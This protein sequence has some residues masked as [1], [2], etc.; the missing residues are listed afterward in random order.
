MRNDLTSRDTFFI[1]L[2]LWTGVILVVAMVGIGGATRLTGS[3]LSIVEWKVISGTIPPLNQMEWEATF[4]KYK[5]FPEYQKLNQGMTLEG[6]KGIFWWEYFHRLIGRFT[7]IAFIVPFLIFVFAKKLSRPLFYQLLGVFV[8]GALQGVMGWVM[9]KSG[10]VDL[11][12]VSH[13]RL[14]A[15]LSLALLLVG[16]L[17]WIIQG[18]SPSFRSDNSH[19]SVVSFTYLFLAVVFIQLIYGAFVAGLK[20]GFSFNTFPLMGSE[21]FP[22]GIYQSAID[23]LENGVMVQFIHR[24]FALVVLAVG[25]VLVYKLMKR[26]YDFVTRQLA[27][28]MMVVLIGQ[29][30]LGIFTL[31]NQVPIILGVLHQLV[32]VGL[33]ALAVMVLYRVKYLS[34]LK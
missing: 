4:D 15:H 19:R 32:G 16:Y 5:Q 1:R 14:A 8:L 23:F 27:I 31:I 11:P 3:G 17:I 33:Y 7:G 25:L 20:A 10:L 12:H 22:T 34:S 13:Y 29:I 18:L 26:S 21:W 9:V 2:W 6:F 30:V 28:W 24:W